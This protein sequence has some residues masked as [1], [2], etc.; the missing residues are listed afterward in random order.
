MQ[1][2]KYYGHAETIGPFE[3]E[4]AKFQGKNQGVVDA[5]G[6]D[7]RRENQAARWKTKGGILQVKSDAASSRG[8]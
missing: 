6:E 8:A 5:L 3:E 1:Q 4:L 7:K 2:C